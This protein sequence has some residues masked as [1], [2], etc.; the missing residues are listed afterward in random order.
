ML[1]DTMLASLARYLPMAAGRSET[2]WDGFRA[3]VRSREGNTR[4]RARSRSLAQT[5]PRQENELRARL[6]FED[7]RHGRPP[8]PLERLP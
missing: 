4:P 2:K 1:P 6:G 5:R 3:M 8:P 7:H